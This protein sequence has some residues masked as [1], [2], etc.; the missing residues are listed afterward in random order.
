VNTTLAINRL[1]VLV[2][3]TVKALQVLWRKRQVYLVLRRP[4][5]PF[6]TYRGKRMYAICIT[7]WETEYCTLYV[8][9][10]F[11]KVRWSHWNISSQ[12]HRYWHIVSVMSDSNGSLVWQSFWIFYFGSYLACD[13][14]YIGKWESR[15]QRNLLHLFLCIC[16][17]VT[18]AK[19]YCSGSTLGQ[20]VIV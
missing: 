12:F 7:Y 14:V 1:F 18:K 9:G 15:I 8:S 13:T 20:F 2:Y 6:S 17:Q 4:F 11:D 5:L 19:T 3:K 10:R 16:F